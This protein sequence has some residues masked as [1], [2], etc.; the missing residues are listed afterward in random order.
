MRACVRA[1]C[2][3]VCV[4][5]ACVCTCAVSTHSGVIV[6][7][8]RDGTIL[9]HDMRTLRVLCILHVSVRNC[10]LGV[11]VFVCVCVCVCVSV[12]VCVCACVCVCKH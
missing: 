2:V 5:H 12:F 9:L 7:G 1:A 10:V 11:S 8:S 3:R 6:T 4:Q